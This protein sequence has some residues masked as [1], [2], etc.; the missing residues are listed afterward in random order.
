ME[1]TDATLLDTVIKHFRGED[2]FAPFLLKF[3][4]RNAGN[5]QGRSFVKELFATR[6]T[7]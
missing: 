1:K 6:Q 7:A 5:V 2:K 3:M 4:E